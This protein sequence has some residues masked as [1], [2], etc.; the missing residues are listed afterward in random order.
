MLHLVLHAFICRMGECVHGLAS[1]SHDSHQ[2][3]KLIRLEGTSLEGVQEWG[4]Y[5]CKT[6]VLVPHARC[7][8]GGRSKNTGGWWDRLH[9]RPH[10]PHELSSKQGRR[11]CMHGDACAPP[12]QHHNR[13]RPSTPSH[14]PTPHPDPGRAGH[15]DLRP[16]ATQLQRT[17]R[18]RSAA[19]RRAQLPC[20]Q[21]RGV[22]IPTT[23]QPSDLPHGHVA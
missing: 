22:R 21:R 18:G 8:I 9:T 11:R 5:H 20:H 15:Q 7:T 10:T 23:A 13:A 14:A 19:H 6:A 12:Q 17:I 16:A 1:V 2:Q 3:L 4:S